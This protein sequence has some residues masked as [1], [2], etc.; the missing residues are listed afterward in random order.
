[1]KH[2][3]L[4]ILVLLPGLWTLLGC[5]PRTARKDTGI[6]TGKVIYQ[7]E[8]LPG[9]AIHFFWG[10]NQSRGV[11]IRGDGSFVAEL[12]VGPVKVAVETDTAKYHG[13]RED[14]MKLWRD[15]AGEDFVHMKQEKLP[16]PP[17]SAPKVVYKKIPAYYADSNKSGLT[18]EVLPGEQQRDFELK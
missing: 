14:M 10:N 9:G 18:Y 12:P 13:N 3:L 1:M 4:V 15:T 16:G 8:P 17:S 6:V 11:A 5:S 7:G 2:R